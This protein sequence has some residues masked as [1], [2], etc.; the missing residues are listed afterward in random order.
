MKFQDLTTLLEQDESIFKPRKIEERKPRHE[1]IIHQQ[2][3]EYIKK[4]AVGNLRLDGSPIKSLPDNLKY[5]GGSLFLDSSLIESVPE[6]LKVRNTLDLGN[7]SLKSLPAGL[8]VGNDL[9][10]ENTLI[11]SLPTDLKVRGSL[12]V[13]NTAISKQY[14]PNQLRRML[15]G[16][17]GEIYI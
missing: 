15:P 14:T 6:G 13:T 9:Y 1:Q 2:I 16:V 3:Q 4:G 8:N 12:Y 5:V 7:T 11:T 17:K 10:L